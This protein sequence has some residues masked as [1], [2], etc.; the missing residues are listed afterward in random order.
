[1]DSKLREVLNGVYSVSSNKSI[2]TLATDGYG[3]VL[4]V[5][6]CMDYVDQNPSKTSSEIVELVMAQFKTEAAPWVE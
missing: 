3:D 1:M 2:A 6:R 4:I 5:E